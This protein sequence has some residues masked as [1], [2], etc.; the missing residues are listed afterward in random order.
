MPLGQRAA[1]GGGA[2]R[3]PCARRAEALRV[4]TI[5]HGTQRQIKCHTM[6]SNRRSDKDRRPERPTGA[7]G[8]L[9][10]RPSSRRI[11]C[12]TMPSK[13][14]RKSLKTHDGHPNE[15]SHF[16][17]GPIS[18]GRAIF[19]FSASTFR[20][21]QKKRNTVALLFQRNSLKT[22]D[23]HPN[24]AKHFFE[25]RISRFAQRAPLSDS[26]FSIRSFLATNHSSLAT[27]LPGGII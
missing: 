4:G 10:D 11:K 7:E 20:F 27:F 16:F 23:G 9:R 5:N 19:R 2:N 3:T 12:H 8:S 22:N 14:T 21:R 26:N 25:G 17:E 6:P 1:S 24:K 15:V 13:F 18:G